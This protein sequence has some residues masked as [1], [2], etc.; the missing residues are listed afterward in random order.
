MGERGDQFPCFVIFDAGEHQVK[1]RIL[2]AK[3]I[4]MKKVSGTLLIAG[5]AWG[6]IISG[7]KKKNNAG[8]NGGAYIAKASFAIDGDD[9]HEQTVTI[10]GVAKGGSYCYYSSKDKVTTAGIDDAPDISHEAKNN[11]TLI[12]NDKTTGTQHA[13]DDTNGGAIGSVYF[14]VTVTDN[15]GTK[16][17]FL[18]E[19]ADNTPGTII[20][21]KFGG[22]GDTVEGTFSGTLVDEHGEANINISR[23]T[24]SVTRNTDID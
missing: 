7:C 20:I 10:T 5:L 24:F 6:L 22:V 3:L 16:H 1:A 8:G 11:L 9:F 23:G 12:F 21:K 17:L 13:G 14:Q 18:F 15:S 2:R 4:I 19:D